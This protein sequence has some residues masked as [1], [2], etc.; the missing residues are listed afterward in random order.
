MHLTVLAYTPRL[1][2]YSFTHI[3]LLCTCYI[4]AALVIYAAIPEL[5]NNLGRNTR[6]QAIVTL[7][8]NCQDRGNSNC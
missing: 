8:S 4:G 3:Y 1:Y 5:T 6:G 2:S 7:C